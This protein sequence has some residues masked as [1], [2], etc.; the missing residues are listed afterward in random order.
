MN[1]KYILDKIRPY[2][3]SKGKFAEDD[4]NKLFSRLTKLHQYHIIN[5]LI[6][7]NIEIDYDRKSVSDNNITN[8]VYSYSD[9]AK[10]NKLSNEQLCVIYQQGNKL[11]LEALINKNSRLV[12]SRAYKYSRRYNHKLDDED[13][14][15][16]GII[17]LIK[18]AERFDLKKEAR[19]TTYAVWWIDQHIC[20]SIA[21]YGFTIRLPVHYFEQI[22]YLMRIFSQNLNCTKEQI[23]LLVKEKGISREKFEEILMVIK[24]IMSPTSLNAYVGDDEESELG[25]FKADDISPSVDEQAENT[26]LKETI[27]LVLNSL[28]PRERDVI[29]KR[30]GL[31]DGE[32]KTLEQVGVI[33]NVTR[34]RIRQ[35]EAK[36]LRKLRH[37]SRSRKL[38]YFL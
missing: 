35:I 26:I 20:R 23:Y 36:A 30:F 37:P 34:E 15:Q 38:K 32:E 24:Y 18:A 6:D 21:D 19:F 17:G 3:N 16:Y 28:T 14:V 33:F 29:E 8:P 11:A 10:I 25:D 1:E 2:I 27:D 4:F 13:L 12:W 5:I 31:R 7:K 9:I 22:N